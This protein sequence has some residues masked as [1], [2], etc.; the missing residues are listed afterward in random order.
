MGGGGILLFVAWAGRCATP[1]DSHFDDD[2]F[3]LGFNSKK[4]KAGYL[5]QVENLIDC[6]NSGYI[7]STT[8]WDTTDDPGLTPDAYVDARLETLCSYNETGL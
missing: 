5:E 8:D 1:G 4:A 6:K 2:G 7:T 3:E